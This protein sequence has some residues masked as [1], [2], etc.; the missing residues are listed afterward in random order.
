MH[1]TEQTDQPKLTLFR[2]CL[3]SYNNG[4]NVILHYMGRGAGG[5]QQISMQ[6]LGLYVSQ[7]VHVTYSVY[8]YA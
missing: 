7:A 8:I 1:L 6:Q 5:R 2:N 3:A 4:V